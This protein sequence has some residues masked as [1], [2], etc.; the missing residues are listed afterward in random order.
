[1]AELRNYYA[2]QVFITFG[3]VLVDPG[4]YHDGD[5]ISIE[6]VSD[7]FNSFVGAGGEVVHSRTNDNRFTVTLRLHQASPTN[8]L[9]SAIAELDRISPNGAGVF[10]L[11]VNDSSGNALYF[12]E[13]ARIMSVPSVS[14]GQEVSVREWTF[15]VA[16]LRITLA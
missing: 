4:A 11:T 15:E 3:A 2:D 7:R 13:K 1:M 9:L 16:D 10:P 12:G 6:P 8:S 14:F 5:F